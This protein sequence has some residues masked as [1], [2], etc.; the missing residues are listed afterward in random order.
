MLGGSLNVL[1]IKQ[2]KNRNQTFYNFFT[3][4][5][6]Q[7]L[8]PCTAHARALSR[9]QLLTCRSERNR[10]RMTRETKLRRSRRSRNQEDQTQII[11]SEEESERSDQRSERR[12]DQRSDQRAECSN[13]S[14]RENRSSKKYKKSSKLVHIALLPDRYQPLQE[15]RTPDP[16]P[17]PDPETQ[18]EKKKQRQKLKKFRK[19]VGKA[20]RYSWKCLIVGLQN[21][22]S[23]YSGPLSAATTL[24]PEA[25]RTRP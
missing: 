18:R 24:V 16:D 23:A 13:N 1:S 10:Y 25:H 4:F 5:S 3:S 19:N 11:E 15:D 7:K 9:E 21:F 22:S 6:L 14:L 8:Q 20:L 12:S 17:D 2:N